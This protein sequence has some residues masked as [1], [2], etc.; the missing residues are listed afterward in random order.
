MLASKSGPGDRM[1]EE[2]RP[3]SFLS[4]LEKHG[5]VRR[6]PKGAILWEQGASFDSV[7]LL[8][9]GRVFLVV[10][11]RREHTSIM[12]IVEPGELF[13]LSCLNAQRRKASPTRAEVAL[14]SEIVSARCEE[15]MRFLR[16]NP[17][18]SL[19]LISNLSERLAYAEE[20]AHIL[21]NHNAED[22]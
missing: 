10:K 13:G 2:V 14:L 21:V 7:H 3:D 9:R 5:S 16:E 8:R 6:Y 18:A 20:R 1:G 12:R 15:C 11:D 4:W 17:D 19:F 22:R